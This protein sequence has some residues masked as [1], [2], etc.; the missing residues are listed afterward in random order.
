MSDLIFIKSLNQ[1]L[2]GIVI[3]CIVNDYRY[4]KIEQE[5]KECYLKQ[6]ITTLFECPYIQYDNQNKIYKCNGDKKE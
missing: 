2:E 3:R 6:I 5:H 1:E 4:Q